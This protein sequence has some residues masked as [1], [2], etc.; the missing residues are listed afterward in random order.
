LDAGLADGITANITTDNKVLGER[1]ASAMIAAIGGKGAVLMFGFDDFEPIKVRGRAAEST[2]A[3]KG[4]TVLEY[5]RVEA[6]TQV[7]EGGVAS[8]KQDA[9]T[10]LANYPKGQLQGIWC[11]WDNCAKGADLAVNELGRTEVAITGIDGQRFAIA[12]IKKG[13]TWKATVKQDWGAIAAKAVELLAVTFQSGKSP[14]N[15]VVFAPPVIID[16][17]NAN[18][19]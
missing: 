19:F 16:S 5:R 13:G 18:K 14:Q 11:A 2:F 1:A 7:A 6:L 10:L 3:A 12:E 4:I 17:T 9:L 8:A 15:G